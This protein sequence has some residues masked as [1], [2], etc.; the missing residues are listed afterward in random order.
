[1]RKENYM[2]NATVLDRNIVVDI[3]VKTFTNDPYTNWLIR[4]SSNQNKNKLLMEY[5]FDETIQ[6]GEI[7]INDS[8]TAVA[9]WN[10][11]R[12]ERI[13][14]DY[15]KRNFLFLQKIGY[16]TCK[17]C[18]D[19]EKVI[20]KYYPKKY[21]HLYLI[22]VLREYQGKGYSSEIINN[23]IERMK[24]KKIPMYLETST[25]KNVAIYSKKG[26]KEYK[27]IER[28]DMVLYL[29]KKEF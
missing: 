7:V 5:L 1:V 27:K 6:K 28:E 20:H 19:M 3:L 21:C 24:D 13:S 29:M 18:I 22:G 14:I 12:N 4:D 23:M 10:Y 25:T 15:F 8:N 17:L 26:F 11:E 16:P 9:L 2:R